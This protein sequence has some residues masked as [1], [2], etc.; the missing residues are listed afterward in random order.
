MGAPTVRRPTRRKTP[1]ADGAC[2]C[3]PRGKVMTSVSQ[4]YWWSMTWLTRA[5]VHR[6]RPIAASPV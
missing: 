3:V 2:V 4:L 6:G 1:I 5:F